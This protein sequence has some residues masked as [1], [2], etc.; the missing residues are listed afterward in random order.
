MIPATA[1]ETRALSAAALLLYLQSPLKLI[2]SKPSPAASVPV[3]FV[4]FPQ[5]IFTRVPA[6]ASFVV[7]VAVMIELVDD[8]CFRVTSAQLGVARGTTTAGA[9]IC[10]QATSTQA[11]LL[12]EV[13]ANTQTPS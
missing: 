10:V 13:V 9:Q 8:F 2:E 11:T 6:R 12:I 4:P 3:M 5:S 7:Q 1:Q